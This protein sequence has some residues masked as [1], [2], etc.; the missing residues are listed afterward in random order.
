[1]KLYEILEISEDAT[2]DDIK[3]SYKKL[4]LLYHPD[5]NKDKDAEVKFSDISKAYNILKDSE[6]RALYD[7]L[8][9]QYKND[10]VNDPFS[11]FKEMYESMDKVP[12][13]EVMVE[14][15]TEDLYYGCSVDKSF[16]RYSL[17]KKCR[18][19][20]TYDGYEHP[21]KKCKGNG[22]ILMELD[23][24]DED[25]FVP[26][27]CEECEGNGIDTNVKLC[28]K[29]KGDTCYKEE[30]T[31]N[32][33]I[34]AGAC[35]GY[36]VTVDNEGNEIPR[37]ERDKK[38]D[39]RSG[40]NFV[41]DEI[42]DDKFKR[43]LI[44]PSLNRSSK[45][46]LMYELNISFPESICGFS[47]DINHISGKKLTIVYKETVLNGEY[48]VLKNKGMPVPNTKMYGDL[49]IK[50]K[51]DRPLLD[52]STSNRMWQILTKEPYSK[53]TALSSTKNLMHFDE[54]ESNILNN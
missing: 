40:V 35:M 53:I 54:F 48:I 9:D 34:P 44:F 2:L 20:G 15:S 26:V 39:R 21:C 32:V 16:E 5:K 3:T 17:C 27:M 25:D 19:K 52:K 28:K 50:I 29:C 11:I 23:D 30:T 47:R 13:V 45:A 24:S 22:S 42:K 12:N 36:V 49:F 31:L 7:K 37:I 41:V 8:G 18:G 10:D 38:S 1:M 4:A 51:V 43:G 6:K 46:D 33:K 14:L